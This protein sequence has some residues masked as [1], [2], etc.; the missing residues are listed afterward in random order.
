MPRKHSNKFMFNYIDVFKM[1]L[2]IVTEYL[3]TMIIINTTIMH[4]KVMK[5]L[6]K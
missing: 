1:T 4:W 5:K 2:Q 3:S 6:L